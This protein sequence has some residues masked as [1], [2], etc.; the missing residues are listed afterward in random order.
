[1]LFLGRGSRLRRARSSRPE[2]RSRWRATS[3]P[4]PRPTVNFPL[5]LTLGV[6]QLRLSAAEALLAATVNGAAALALADQVGQI[7]P[8]FSADLALFEAE[9]V[10][11]LPYWY[12]DRRCMGTWLRGKTCQPYKLPVYLGSVCP[13]PS[14]QSPRSL[15]E[16]C[17]ALMSNVAK[18]KKRA[19]RIRAE[20][21]VR[22]G[23]RRSTS[24]SSRRCDGRVGRRRRAA[25]QPRGRSLAPHGQRRGRAE[26]L[27]AG[28]RSVRRRAASSTTRSR[29]ATRFSASRRAAHSIY[30]KLG[31]ISANEGIQ[32]RREEELPRVRRPHAEG[33]ADRR[34][35][36]RAEGVRRS[37]SRSG[38]HPADA[39]RA[40]GEGGSHRTRRSSSCRSSTTSSIAKGARRKRAPP[41][42]A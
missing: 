24:S 22:Q 13:A 1:M 14:R 37:L 39:G 18:L 19:A 5:I 28:R 11:E 16:P 42:T 32:Q 6:S 15:R 8:G 2:R 12:G 3:T 27:R 20:K 9:D 7:T 17:H 33:G 36:P 30:Y 23:A 25:L 31:K 4:E 26:L 41:S 29:S 34:G 38:R 40:A 21:A 10:R 35:V